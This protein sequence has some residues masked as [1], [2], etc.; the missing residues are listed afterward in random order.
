MQ[1]KAGISH[2]LSV[3]CVNSLFHLADFIR[4]PVSC[5]ICA[6]TMAINYDFG[7]RS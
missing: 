6:R 5:K 7:N 4:H 2:T 3:A 1:L